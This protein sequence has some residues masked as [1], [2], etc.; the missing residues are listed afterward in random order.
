MRPYTRG[1][2]RVRISI[3]VDPGMLQSFVSNPPTGPKLDAPE[4][5]FYRRFY[6]T[7][8]LLSLVSPSPTNVV[9]RHMNLGPS[10]VYATTRSLHVLPW[11]Y[12]ILSRT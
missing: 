10:E 6:C 5:I 11:Y 8:I 2:R 4:T 9:D 7:I 3:R 1:P 12:Y